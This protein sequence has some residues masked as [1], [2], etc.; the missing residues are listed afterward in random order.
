MLVLLKWVSNNWCFRIIR[1][2]C[3]NPISNYYIN[4][5]TILSSLYSLTSNISLGFYWIKKIL[6]IVFFII[7]NHER[8]KILIYRLLGK[9]MIYITS[10][11]MK[12]WMKTT[13]YLG[14]GGGASCHVASNLNTSHYV[15]SY[16]YNIQFDLHNVCEFPIFIKSILPRTPSRIRIYPWSNDSL[17]LF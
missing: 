17:V 16:L 1:V 14:G 5:V 4:S 11:Q 15:F 13:F 8:Y 2:Y 9:Y 3:Q 6:V 7:W 12:G 10:W